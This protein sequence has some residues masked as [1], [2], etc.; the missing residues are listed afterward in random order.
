MR[1]EADRMGE[2]PCEGCGRWSVSRFRPYR[3]RDGRWLCPP[4]WRKLVDVRPGKQ[5][6]HGRRR[7]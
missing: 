2:A 4:C 7:R 6:G 5:L 3:G 1:S